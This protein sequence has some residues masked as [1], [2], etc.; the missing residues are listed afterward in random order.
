MTDL[1]P[2]AGKL[3]NFVRLLAS[4]KDGEVVGA[5]RA[6]NRVLKSIGADFHDLA[7]RV[8]KPGGEI[9]DADME[10]IYKAGIEE[11][12]RQEKQARA[13]A[14]GNGS[15]ANFPSAQDMAM[16]CYQNKAKL[17]SEW[18]LEFTDNMA[19]WTRTVRPLSPK[20]QAHLEKI[21]IKLGGRI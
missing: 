13:M 2:I 9:S 5:A 21:Y 18:E 12:Q 14:R 4:D 17:R 16:F 1:K 3:A 20:Q 10:K 7:D 19:A 8:E 6:L 15:S 11:G